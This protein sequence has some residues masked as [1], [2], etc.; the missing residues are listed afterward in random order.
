MI[1]YRHRFWICSCTIFWRL[2]DPM[3]WEW[4]HKTLALKINLLKV[5]TS[6]QTFIKDALES[7]KWSVFLLRPSSILSKYFVKTKIIAHMMLVS[8]SLLLFVLFC[9]VLRVF[10]DLIKCSMLVV[11]L[12]TE[13]IRFPFYINFLNT[14]YAGSIS[15]IF[16]L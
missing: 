2:S 11:S 8:H 9:S 14:K 10:K 5:K 15:H 4:E 1:I 16:F 6:P 7:C 13:R 12:L 3:I